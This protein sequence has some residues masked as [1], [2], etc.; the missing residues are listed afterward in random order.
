MTKAQKDGPR[1][2]K[3]A[4]QITIGI[5]GLGLIGGSMAKAIQ[6]HTAHAVW[7]LDQ[8]EA[9]QAQALAEG[10]L[11]G[12]LDEDSLARCQILLLALYPGDTVEYLTRQEQN[13]PKG[14]WVV[15]LC[16]IKR[17]V[18][19]AALPLAERRGFHF[20]G[21]HPMAGKERSGYAV[22]HENLFAGASMLLTPHS[23]AP[24]QVTAGLEEFFFSLGFGTVHRTTPEEHDRVIAYTSQLAHVLSNAYVQS[25]AALRHRE[26]SGGSFQDLTRVATLNEAM[27]TELFLENQDFLL[28]ELEGLCSRLQAYRDALAAG[29]AGELHALLREGCRWKAEIDRQ[30]EPSASAPLCQWKKER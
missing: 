16:G 5:V 22:S 3:E 7:G 25:P 2:R 9:V 20:V 10:V 28:D 6:R 21:G 15:D 4:R 17:P 26:F 23:A 14:A 11:D 27:W 8:N 29:N 12:I 1:E 13:I 24:A 30:R 18:C 19:A